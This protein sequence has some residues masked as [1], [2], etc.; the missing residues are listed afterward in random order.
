MANGCGVLIAYCQWQPTDPDRRPDAR[1]ADRRCDFRSARRARDQRQVTDCEPAKLIDDSQVLRP[2]VAPRPRHARVRI[3]LLMRDSTW[4][5]RDDGD[6]MCRPAP[7]TFRGKGAA[8]RHLSSEAGATS[9][10]LVLEQASK[11][12]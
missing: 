4:P 3:C 10:A 12:K 5:W 7:G 9:E 1:A 11:Q 2:F 6:R 8:D